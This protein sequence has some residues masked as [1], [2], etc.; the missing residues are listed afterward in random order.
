MIEPEERAGPP[1]QDDHADHGP[2]EADFGRW[3][4]L[5]DEYQQAMGD[6]EQSSRIATSVEF[7]T[8]IAADIA[9]PTTTTVAPVPPPAPS[10]LAAIAGAYVPS[11]QLPGKLSMPAAEIACFASL[12]VLAILFR[13]AADPRGGEEFCAND[14][15][16]TIPELRAG[17]TNS[18]AIGTYLGSSGLIVV[19]ETI[20][21]GIDLPKVTGHSPFWFS[22]S[23]EAAAAALR[24][25]ASH[26]ELF[27]SDAQV[28]A[29]AGATSPA[30]L[31]A[32]INRLWSHSRWLAA[33][34]R[35]RRRRVKRRRR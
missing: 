30:D 9:R 6:L 29:R 14:L 5:E 23:F 8:G 35:G 15:M 21:P 12:G 18:N 11:V 20:E 22:P 4:A 19:S 1:A 25:L 2:S 7:R 10:S 3:L 17:F 28:A 34:P 26:P 27:W 16:A 13:A 24:K 32:A 31:S 33:Y